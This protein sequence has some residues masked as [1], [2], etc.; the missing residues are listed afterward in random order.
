[1]PKEIKDNHRTSC[2]SHSNQSLPLSDNDDVVGSNLW[3]LRCR[4]SSSS[5]VDA[6]EQVGAVLLIP[7]IGELLSNLASFELDSGMS[8]RI[9]SWHDGPWTEFSAT[10][11][12]AA[13]V[14]GNVV[15]FVFVFVVA[16]A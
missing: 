11:Q 10:G 4:I 8:L 14:P 3:I 2:S 12:E 15:S 13:E 16:V 6:E 7:D 5:V 1:M 9:G